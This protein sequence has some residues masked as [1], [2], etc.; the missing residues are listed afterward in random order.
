MKKVISQIILIL[1][2]I[3]QWGAAT[4]RGGASCVLGA[5]WVYNWDREGNHCGFFLLFFLILNSIGRGTGG[6]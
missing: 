5:D 3:P 4:R 6:L 1:L 2:E